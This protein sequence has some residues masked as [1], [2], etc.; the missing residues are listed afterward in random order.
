[1]IDPASTTRT[2]L[3]RRSI[4]GQDGVRATE[5]QDLQLRHYRFAEPWQPMPAT[6]PVITSSITP[7]GPDIG[8]LGLGCA[9]LQPV[10]R[11][12]GRVE[13]VC[14]WQVVPGV[15]LPGELNVS[16]RLQDA[17]QRTIV[18]LDQPLAPFGMPGIAY[19]KTIVTSYVMPLRE[20]AASPRMLEIITYTPAGE[21][22]PR[23]VTHIDGAGESG[24]LPAS[25][26]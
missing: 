16:L 12:E 26:P 25:Q 14:F 9:Q 24:E 17:A 22:T 8:L 1:M 23:I 18:Q 2:L 5:F 4:P 6:R 13:V 11:S 20:D 7:H 10:R 3:V 15:R 21:I 19:E